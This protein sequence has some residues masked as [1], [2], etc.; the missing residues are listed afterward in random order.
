VGQGVNCDWE[1]WGMVAIAGRKEIS[2]GRGD[3]ER[4]INPG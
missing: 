3:K 2:Y 1:G 4:K